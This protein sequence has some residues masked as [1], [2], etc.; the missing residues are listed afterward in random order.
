VFLSTNA[1]STGLNLQSADTVINVDLPWNPAV[2]EQRIAR[3]H[4][5]GQK[6]PVNVYILVTQE[7][8]EENLLSVIGQ[9]KEL[10]TAALDYE[11]EISEVRLQSGM[12]ELKSRLEVLLGAVPE[13]HQ[14]ESQK[15]AR[16]AEAVQLTAR[17]EKMAEAGGQ[18]LTAAFSLLSQMLPDSAATPAPEVVSQIRQH[19]TA[20]AETD[21]QGR[22]SLRITLPSD[23]SLNQFAETL[24]RLMGV[25]GR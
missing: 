7:T 11:S 13:G 16:A 24:A 3:A 14:D 9:K 8:L 15:R 10:A 4:R 6:R 19:L 23:D 25:G 17:R 12:D 5:M 2:L 18:M 21:E 22:R 20:S 1:G